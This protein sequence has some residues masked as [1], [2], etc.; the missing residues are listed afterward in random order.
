M[1]GCLCS[2]VPCNKHQKPQCIHQCQV[3]PSTCLASGI[4]GIGGDAFQACFGIHCFGL[5]EDSSLLLVS[6]L[7]WLEN[8]FV[9]SIDCCVLNCFRAAKTCFS[10]R[11]FICVEH[12]RCTT[13]IGFSLWSPSIS[14]HQHGI[15]H[16]DFFHI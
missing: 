4:P 14:R 11:L 7:F 2:A 5:L 10:T 3:F 6:F 16:I 12:F 1:E 15:F 13:L 8:S 9:L